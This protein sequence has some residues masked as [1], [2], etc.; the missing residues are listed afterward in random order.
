MNEIR[1]FSFGG[2]VQSVAALALQSM[3]KLS[4]DK[5]VFANVG[6][7]AENPETLLYYRGVVIPFAQRN[8]I[9]IVETQ[10]LKKGEPYSLLEAIRADNRSIPIPVFMGNGAPGRRTCTQD[11]KIGVVDRYIRSLKVEKAVIGLGISIDEFVRA[12]DT[13]W[14]DAHGTKKF[15][16]LKKREYPLIDMRLTRMDCINLIEQTGLPI[17]PKSSCWFCPFHRKNTWIDLRRNHPERFEAA[18]ELENIINRH[19]EGLGMDRV[20]LHQSARPLE[21]AVGEQSSLFDDVD[22]CEGYCHT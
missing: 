13:D 20:Y 11:W 22:D 21:K 17:P 19:R 2:G 3:G 15:G 5:F 12:R 18:V 8:G 1:I 16:F 10:R 6:D 9:E 4:Y 14:H 7:D